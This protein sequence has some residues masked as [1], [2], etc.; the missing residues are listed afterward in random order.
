MIARRIGTVVEARAARPGLT[1]L[2]VEVDGARAG[3]V[4]YDDLAG[5]VAAGDRVLLNTTAVDLG[6]GTGGVHFVIAVAGEET[7][8]AGPAGGD[9]IKLRYTPMQIA[10]E[11]VEERHRDAIDALDGLGGMPVVAAGLHSAL[12]P[13]AI[14]ARAVA[15]SCRIVSI[16]TEG[17]ALPLAFSRSVAALRDAGL[18]DATI[19]A[20]Q[21]FG[22]DLEAVTLHGALAAA[23]AVCGAD[24]AIVAMGPGNLGTG[25]RWGFA[26]M[27]VAAVVNAVAAMG[28][29]PIVAPRLSFADAR[30]RHRG[31]SHHTVTALEVMLARAEVALPRLA[32]DRDA[33]VRAR[34]GAVA[35]RHA[36]VDVDLGPAEEAL[37]RAPVPLETMGRTYADDPEPFRAAAAAGVLAARGL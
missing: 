11:A 14:G 29:R 6:L 37:A 7:G 3:A 26:L 32:P 15:P 36:I 2:V 28:G 23:R 18:I 31:L 22:G 20:G 21:A 10:V 30:D 19:T 1:E 4:S 16:T 17:G 13:A 35:G 12:A 24:L 33:A 27:E 8:A 34:L 9:A 25:S 5:P